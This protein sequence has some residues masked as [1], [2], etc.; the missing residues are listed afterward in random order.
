[1]GANTEG[2]I[3]RLR[4]MDRKVRALDFRCRACWSCHTDPSAVPKD[5]TRMPLQGKP[6]L[7]LAP[8]EASLCVGQRPWDD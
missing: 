8:A 6:L 7:P 2:S 1:M 3:Q 5:G 4:V